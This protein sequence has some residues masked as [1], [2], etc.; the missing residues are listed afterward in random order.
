MDRRA[1]R[2]AMAERPDVGLG[3]RL[4]REGVVGRDGSVGLDAN[5]LA[6][7]AREVLRRVW[8]S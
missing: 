6:Q 3:T 7:V 2:V 8:P 4:A 5:Y 1:K